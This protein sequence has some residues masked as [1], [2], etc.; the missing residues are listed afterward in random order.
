MMSKIS[1]ALVTCALSCAAAA[2]FENPP[3]FSDENQQCTDDE[4]AIVAA[5]VE[6]GGDDAWLTMLQK[7]A[8]A[9]MGN[10]EKSLAAMK[11]MAGS[12]GLSDKCLDCQTMTSTCGFWKCGFKYCSDQYAEKCME[13]GGQ[14]CTLESLCGGSGHYGNRDKNGKPINATYAAKLKALADVQ[15]ISM[16]GVP[17]PTP[18]PT[19]AP[20]DTPAPEPSPAPATPSGASESTSLAACG[21]SL[22]SVVVL[23]FGL[24][25]FLQ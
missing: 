19:S 9:G 8:I 6:A 22:A 20:A 17:T 16:D 13:C 4:K 2:A 23:V 10:H 25:C 15:C 11:K 14:F 3:C 7:A 5:A 18:A 1:Q 24:L 12:L 21:S